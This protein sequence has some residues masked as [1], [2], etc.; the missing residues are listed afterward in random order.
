MYQR[1]TSSKQ[2]SS[3]KEEAKYK[4][5][6]KAYGA[7]RQYGTKPKLKGVKDVIKP[8]PNTLPESVCF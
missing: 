2:K 7:K 5:A 6:H 1:P 4:K 8:A 3:K